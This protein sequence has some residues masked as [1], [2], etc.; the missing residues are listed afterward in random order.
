MDSKEI[1]YCPCCDGSKISGTNQNIKRKRQKSSIKL[2]E[3]TMKATTISGE[4]AQ[5]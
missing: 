4:A 2:M 1:V 5:R 3:E